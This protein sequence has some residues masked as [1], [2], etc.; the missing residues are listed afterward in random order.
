MG[1]KPQHTIPEYDLFVSYSPAD[2]EWVEGYLLDALSTANVRVLSERN[3]ALGAPRINELGRA[4]PSSQCCY[5]QM[6]PTGD[7]L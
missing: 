4:T 6:W 2:H 3:F 1:Q 7:R 5:W